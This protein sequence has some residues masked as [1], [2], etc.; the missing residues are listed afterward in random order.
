MLVMQLRSVLCVYVRV[1]FRD[2]GMDLWITGATGGEVAACAS[3]MGMAT[4]GISMVAPR[5]CCFEV[6]PGTREVSFTV[7]C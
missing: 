4:S 5:W 1:L 2:V 3:L 7:L 6:G